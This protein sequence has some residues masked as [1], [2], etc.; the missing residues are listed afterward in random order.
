[1]ISNMYLFVKIIYRTLSYSEYWINAIEYI[2]PLYEDPYQSP[3][4]RIS[5]RV[6]KVYNLHFNDFEHIH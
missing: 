5:V 1:M 2:D 6:L 4:S 3:A